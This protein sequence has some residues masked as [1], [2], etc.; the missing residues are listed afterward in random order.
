MSIIIFLLAI[1]CLVVIHELGH[2]LAARM[3]GVKADEFGF[4]FPPRLIGFV[5]VGKKWKRVKGEDQTKYANTIWS[6]NWLPLGGFVRIKGEEKE[7]INDKDSIH[8]KPIWQRIVIISAGVIMNWALATVLFIA[9]FVGGTDAYLADVPASA[10]IVNRHVVISDVIVDSPAAKAGIEPGDTVVSVQG[11]TLGSSTD[12]RNAIIAQGTSPVTVGVVR[13]GASK[14]FNV[15]PAV[16]AETGHP[17]L[18]VAMDDIGVV[19]FSFP[20]AVYYGA[21]MTVM[22]TQSIVLELGAVGKQILFAHS[23]PADV[24]GPVGIAV[25]A[26]HVAKQGWAPFLQFAALLSVNLAVIN[27][28]PIPALDGGRVL[29]LIIEKIR[30]KPISR[31]LEIGIHNVAFIL[32]ILLIFFVTLHDISRYGGAIVGGVKG[33]VGL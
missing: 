26:G 23:V 4:G 25:M 15:T 8:V 31:T 3:F 18:G 17:G 9:I 30:R 24:S 6:L 14:T 5:R 22:T 20:Q 1:S 28:L 19:T 10:H 2:Y 16:L 21:R 27:F 32:L 33:M 29:F 13:D 11:T 12:V 7:G